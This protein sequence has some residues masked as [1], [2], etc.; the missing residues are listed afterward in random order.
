MMSPVRELSLG[1]WFLP[2]VVLAAAAVAAF[3]AAPAL[4]ERRFSDAVALAGRVLLLGAMVAVV[5]V[6]LLQTNAVPEEFASPR[7]LNLVPG[8]EIM[9]SLSL[10]NRGLGL[11][12]VL[13]NVA[14]FVPVGLL[15]V[16]G[17][18]LRAGTATLL[19]MALSTSVEAAQ[20]LLGR[21]A[22]ID[23]VLLNTTGTL[24]GALAAVGLATLASAASRR[25]A[26]S[27]AA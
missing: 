3:A 11:V 27:V 19:G 9:I 10:E 18:G 26:R 17:L 6:T 21:V 15:A 1:P 2:V 8:Q 20:Y 23:D 14:M 7:S 12:N 13:G 5:V 16:I 22:D 24:V 25:R 4:R